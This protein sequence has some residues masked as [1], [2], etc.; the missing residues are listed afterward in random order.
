MA[1][2]STGP[3]NRVKECRHGTF[4]YNV[5]DQYIGRSLDRYGES[6]EIELDFFKRVIEPGDVIVDVG[7]NIGTHTVF[8]AKA[9]GITGQVYAFEP[10]RLMF[11]TLCAN[12]ALNSLVNV[13]ARQA[14]V[15]DAP[16][17]LAVPT[18]D[19]WVEQNFGG[20]QLGKVNAGEAVPVITIDSMNLPNCHLMKVDVEGMELAVLKGAEKT[21]RKYQ[22]VLYVE[23]D[24]VER[25]E[26]LV[27]YIDSLEYEMYRHMPPLFNPENFLKNTENVFGTI[28]SNNMICVPVGT[29]EG[30]SLETKVVVPK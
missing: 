14:A 1:E 9:T 21:I 10:Q 23:N 24:R 27:K 4:V 20:M 29:L 5:N 3:F 7:A 15:S 6:S 8:F 30:V 18:L 2:R 19:P 17:E 26:A 11:Q 25:S 13:F 28:V 16:G 12:L 22:P